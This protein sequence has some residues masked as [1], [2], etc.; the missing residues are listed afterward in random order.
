[1]TQ[2]TFTKLSQTDKPLYG[3]RK[4][5]LCGFSTQARPNFLKVLEMACLADVPVVWA[6]GNDADTLLSELMS[7]PGGSGSETDSEL[8][9]AVVV[10]GIA[11]KELPV[12]MSACR[13][14]GMGQSLWAVLT[15]TSETWTL[16]TL[17]TELK[18]ERCAMQKRKAE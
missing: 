4:L 5:L 12:L 2:S 11:Q 8:P 14:A 3:P 16:K 18:A 17:L 9:R 7:R 15:P 10:G 13:Q 1:M 6:D